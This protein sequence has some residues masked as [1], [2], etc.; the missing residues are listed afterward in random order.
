LPQLAAT[1][2]GWAEVVLSDFDAF[3]LDHASCERKAAASAL[4]L[5]ARHSDQAQLVEPLTALAREELEHFGQV[6]RLIQ[7]RGLRLGPDDKD[8]YVNRLLATLRPEPGTRLLDRL[9]A[10][11]LIE[12]RSSE[13]FALLTCALPSGD[14]LDF[15]RALH[16]SEAGHY[17]VFTRLAARLFGDAPAAAAL[18]R[19]LPLE[20]EAMRATP[21]RP[22]VH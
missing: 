11:A 21:F 13:R 16:R 12:A 17:R 20:A 1:P 6:F 14:L 19:L 4:S 18:A 5:L 9:V 8:P 2:A 15:Y 10:S 3:L 7:R 22:A